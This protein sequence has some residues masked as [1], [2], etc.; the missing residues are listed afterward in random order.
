MIRDTVVAPENHRGDE[1]EH[2]LRADI[3][4]A[5]IIRKRIHAEEPFDR[6][7]LDFENPGVHPAPVFVEF[8]DAS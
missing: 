2:F 7:V 8:L 5:C 6:P 1:S 3:Q 4:R